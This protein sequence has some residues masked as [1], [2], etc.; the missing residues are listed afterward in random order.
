MKANHQFAICLLVLLAVVIGAS[1][2]SSRER[3]AAPPQQKA[4]TAPAPQN[5]VD[6]GRYLVDGVWRS[7]EPGMVLS[8]EP[9]IYI[10]EPVTSA[11][12]DDVYESIGVRLEDTV[13]VTPDGCE[14]LTASAPT[15][16]D[17]VE[18]LMATEH[19]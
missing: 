11:V 14:V 1:R 18:T 5:L 6:R 8:V 17:A 7:L 19:D 2:L 9:G 16:P 13:L 12:G 4:S 3:E 10:V 15:D